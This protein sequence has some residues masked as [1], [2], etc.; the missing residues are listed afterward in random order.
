[1]KRILMFLLI[2]I[3]TAGNILSQTDSKRIVYLS[4]EEVIGQSLDQNLSLRSK[5]LDYESQNLEVWNSYS[6]FLPSLT[7][8][9]YA[10]KNIE[11]PVFVF[12]GEEFT[13]GTPYTFQHTFTAS[14]PI[15]TGG[16]RLF[17]LSAQKSLKK[18]LSEE[19]KGKESETVLDG[20]KSYYGIILAQSLYETSQEAVSV[21]QENLDQVQKQYDAGTGTELDLQ[22]AKAQYYSTLPSF[23]SAKSN[24]RLS[25]QQLKS[26]LDMPLNDSLVVVDTLAQREFLDN[27]D[28]NN[29]EVLKTTGFANRHELLAMRHQLD[30]TKEGEKIALSDFAPKIALSATLDYQAQL[31]N[32]NVSW[33][34]YIRSKTVALSVNWPIFEGG[35]KIIEYQKAKIRT[36]QMSMSLKQF[37][38]QTELNIEQSFY[39]FRE[40]Q[41]NLSSL[42]EALKQSKESLRISN[43]LYEQ[44]MSTQLDV[45]NA[46]LLYIN[47]KT[48]YQQGI[49]DYNISQLSLLN[50]IGKL[51]TIWN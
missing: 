6:T 15:F 13:V 50:S 29:L 11:L 46:Q 25:K 10:V 7:Y 26:F 33:S 38:D 35:S 43:L 30:A 41:K 17:N 31:E 14:V 18:S 39:A 12:M 8:D 40:A 48:D 42:Y 28:V 24:L 21:A 16:S 23:E 27:Y 4:M 36:D 51:N 1:M 32:S 9:G 22:R 37:E 3:F 34:D 19:L 20:L 45:L 47:S 2:L 5:I 49:Y 44:G